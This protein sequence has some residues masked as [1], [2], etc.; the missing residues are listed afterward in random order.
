VQ[1][2]WKCLSGWDVRTGRG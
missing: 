2:P 1:L